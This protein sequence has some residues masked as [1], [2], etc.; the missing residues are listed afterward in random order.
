M[1][2]IEPAI[3]PSVMGLETFIPYKLHA[4]LGRTPLRNQWFDTAMPGAICN[5]YR[6]FFSFA[7][8]PQMNCWTR[9]PNPAYFIRFASWQDKIS[10][11]PDVSRGRPLPPLLCQDVKDAL[12]V[13]SGCP[14][15][16]YSIRFGLCPGLPCSQIS[17]NTKWDVM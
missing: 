12:R 1:T 11:T 14:Y 7:F 4:S 17:Q 6:T 8:A 10:S 2:G 9:M 5:Y 13:R 3:F 16:R 15:Q